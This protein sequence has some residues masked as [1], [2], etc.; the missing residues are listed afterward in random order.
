MQNY[1]ILKKQLLQLFKLIYYNEIKARELENLKID[2]GIKK[3][4]DGFN[5]VKKLKDN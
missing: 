4:T 2:D 5:G 3:G 1:E